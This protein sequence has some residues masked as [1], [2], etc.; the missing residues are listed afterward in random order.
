M[1]KMNKKGFTMIE[2]LA[3]I[4]IIA[5]L[6]A[7]IV[8]AVGNSTMK[9]KAASDAANLR[10]QA[11]SIAIDYLADNDLD[12]AYTMDV[13][14]DGTTNQVIQSYLVDGEIVVY[15]PAKT[16]NK[17]YTIDALATA[18]DSGVAPTSAALPTGDALGT[19]ITYTAPAN[20]EGGQ[21]G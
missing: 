6:V 9:A 4:A 8:P 17:F 15:V 1:K 11:A 10:S 18:A 13:E 7:I 19:S 16:A 3:V 12:K 14:V 20:P 21:Q 5:I 2:M